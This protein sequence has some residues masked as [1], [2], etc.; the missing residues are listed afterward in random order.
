MASPAFILG[1][2]AT[3]IF[4]LAAWLEPRVAT[5]GE[6]RDTSKSVVEVLLGDGRR[7]FANHFFVKADVYFH[8]GYYPSVFD[9]AS[10]SGSS[11][12]PLAVQR[13]AEPASPGNHSGEAGHVE[14]HEEHQQK[15]EH[16]AGGGRHDEA[17]HEREM[18]FLGKPKDWIDR[19]GRNFFVSGHAH[20]GGGGEQRELLPWF[21]L[22]ADMDPHRIET[23]TLA[24]YWLTTFLNQPDEAIAFLREG[25]QVNRDS[26]AI[27]LE[28]GAIY[29]KYK[30]DRER[31]RNFLG[32]ALLKWTAQEGAKPDADKAPYR[33]ILVRLADLEERDG[34]LPAALFLRRK[35][36]LVSPFPDTIQKEIEE[37]ERKIAAPAA[38]KPPAR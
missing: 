1:L 10:A 30:N 9:Q 28:L 26:Y 38:A 29:D 19:F 22:S 33:Q 21:R 35:L 8:R 37:L 5:W 20:L 17:E 4:G 23:Y 31:A 24:A 14:E 12:A 34:N 27:L 16:H 36:K 6:G 32:A 18:D 25:W 13:A 15:E 2:L 7:M 11:Q 3:L